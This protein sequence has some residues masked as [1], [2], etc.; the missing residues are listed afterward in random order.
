M[1]LLLP[2]IVAQKNI[3]VK[4][5]N[6][7][8]LILSVLNRYTVSSAGNSIGFFNGVDTLFRAM[9]RCRDKLSVLIINVGDAVDFLRRRFLRL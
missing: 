8:A 3:N 6:P 9:P 4:K 7:K 5:I 1:L 2:L